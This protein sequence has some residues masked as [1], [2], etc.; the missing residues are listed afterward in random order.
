MTSEE[1]IAGFKNW[2]REKA[3]RFSEE[4]ILTGI[5]KLY[6]IGIIEKSLI[7]YHLVA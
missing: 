4:E 2:S 1:I 3:N 7:G 5:Q 6:A